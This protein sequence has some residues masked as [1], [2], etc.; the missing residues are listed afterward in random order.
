M[1]AA[2]SFLAKVVALIEAGDSALVF[3]T[4]IF[5]SQQERKSAAQLARLADKYDYTASIQFK[6]LIEGKS[7]A[8]IDTVIRKFSEPINRALKRSEFLNAVKLMSSSDEILELS[9]ADACD[10]IES[11]RGFLRSIDGP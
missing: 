6:V 5:P 3:D 10:E 11:V 8:Y 4:G 1:D 9:P 2:S 7:Q